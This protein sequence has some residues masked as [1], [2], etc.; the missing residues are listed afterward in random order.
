M[1]SLPIITIFESHQ[2][3]LSEVL[4]NKL[5]PSLAKLGYDT[6]C[7]E[8]PRNMKI[9]EIIRIM[10]FQ[11]EKAEE[12]RDR[13]QN[14]LKSRGLIQQIGDIHFEALFSLMKQYL[15][16]RQESDLFLTANQ[17][18]MIPATRAYQELLAE[19]APRNSI[20]IECIDINEEEIPLAMGQAALQLDSKRNQAMSQKLLELYRERKGLIFLAGGRHAPIVR[21]LQKN[22][23]FNVLPFFPYSAEIPFN[24]AAYSNDQ[25]PLE[26]LKGHIFQV[27][28]SQIDCFAQGVI[29]EVES[30]KVRYHQA[31]LEG[32]YLAQALSIFFQ[33]DFKASMREGCYVDAHLDLDQEDDVGSMVEKLTEN[34]IVSYV[35]QDPQE[36]YLI[37]P[38]INRDPICGRIRQLTNK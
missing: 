8:L 16:H 3:L 17:I 37:I 1:T 19:V 38:D 29:A 28:K 15:P 4:L 10:S 21:L 27:P 33:A 32:T 25:T 9:S 6:L 13:T 7:L 18:A 36:K 11:I 24:W 34:Q 2:D 35:S 22:N 14:L 20:G 12:E 5:L 23:V 31:L 26:I 30:H